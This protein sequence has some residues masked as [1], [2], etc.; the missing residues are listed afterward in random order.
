[1]QYLDISDRPD[2]LIICGDIHGEFKTLV[3]TIGQK[4]ISDATI[5]VAGDCGFG[6]SKYA[7]YRCLYMHLHPKLEKQNVL[8]LMVRGNHD[9]PRYFSEEMIDFPFMKTLPDY[10]VVHTMSHNVLCIGGAISIDRNFRLSKMDYDR[11]L[12]KQ[13][14]PLYWPGESVIYDEAQLSL[15]EQEQVWIDSVVTH[16][17]PAFCPPLSKEGLEHWSAADENLPDDISRERE[18]MTRIY[19]YLINHRHPLRTWYYGHYHASVSYLRG[20][21]L[22]RLLDIMELCSCAWK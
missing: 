8:L 17:A 12:G 2:N 6:F 21:V 1:M 10:T 15:L 13:S 4:R 19:D 11:I 9:D 16:T 22:F 14:N 7:Y 18:T 20:N 5:I 3:Y